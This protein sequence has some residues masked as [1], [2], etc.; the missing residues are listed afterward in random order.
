MMKLLVV[1]GVVL[2]VGWLLLKGRRGAAP[3]PRPGR[4][5]GDGA[6]PMVSCSH[7]GLHLPRAEAVGA[8]DGGFFC[9][10]EHRRLGAK[11]G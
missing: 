2:V 1:V 8:A 3:K 5:G 4:A 11:G 10:D 6:Q 9:S 7:C